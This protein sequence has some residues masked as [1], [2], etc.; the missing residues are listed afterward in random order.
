MS[1][2][3]VV[4]DL[5]GTL[6]NTLTDLAAS[7]NRALLQMG[8]TTHTTDEIRSF[9]GNGARLLCHRAVGMDHLKPRVL[10]DLLL[11]ARYDLPEH[12]V[13]GK[14]DFHSVHFVFLLL[15]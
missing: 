9:I 12:K 1:I 8:R 15:F 14:R 7:C 5:D 4:F 11:S 10:D 13:S 6:L 2:K 3:A